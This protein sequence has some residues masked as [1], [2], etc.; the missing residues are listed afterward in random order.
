MTFYRI[1]IISLLLGSSPPTQAWQKKP[2]RKPA[3]AHKAPVTHKPVPLATKLWIEGW[4]TPHTEN[5]QRPPQW[6]AED[7]ILGRMSCP[8]LSRVLLK[9]KK[10]DLLLLRGI[11]SEENDR[12]W[13]FTLRSGLY[14]WDGTSV[15]NKDLR[16]FIESALEDTAKAKSGGLWKIPSYTV[17]EKIDSIEVRFSEV[18]EI[19]P[20]LFNGIPLWKSVGGG[21]PPDLPF[22][23]VG[24]YRLRQGEKPGDF[25]LQAVPQ[26]GL[27][28]TEIQV[29]NQIPPGHSAFLSFQ[30]AESLTVQPAMVQSRTQTATMDLPWMTVLA[31][32]TTKH[33]QAE[34]RKALAALIPRQALVQT[35]AGTLGTLSATLLPPMHPAHAPKNRPILLPLTQALA[36]IKKVAPTLQRLQLAS[37]GE[38]GHLVEKVLEDTFHAAGIQIEWV[39]GDGTGKEVDGSLVGMYL[40]WPQMNLLPD[41]H[42]KMKGLS[43]L[44]AELD[45]QLAA[46]A[47]SLTRE[48]P[49]FPAVTK[50]EDRW[51]QLEAITAM[52]Q[53]KARVTGT[54]PKSVL[55]S[56]MNPD[57]FKQAIP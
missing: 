20:Y 52:M 46:Y 34:E 35:G 23:C 48:H 45:A 47:Q 39:T 1:F 21:K 27:R 5:W 42:S 31:W 9:E 32:N 33:P 54:A 56:L 53:H 44:D 57:W 14:W 43:P 36:Q 13:R 17:T 49:D 2:S 38:P 19:G 10:S 26:Y 24:T 11:T 51:V 18:P 28:T 8:P 7:P 16:L 25:T 50:I 37:P 6:L 3:P 55:P 4:P 29:V 12:I 30:M 15:S 41:L 22:Q 40:P